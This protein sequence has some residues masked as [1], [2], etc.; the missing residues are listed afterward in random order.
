MNDETLAHQVCELLQAWNSYAK[1]MTRDRVISLPSHLTAASDA[2]IKE[3][4]KK[5]RAHA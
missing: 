2:M 1:E 3:L 4:S 5:G